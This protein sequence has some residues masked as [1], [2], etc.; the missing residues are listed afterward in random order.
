MEMQD[1][2]SGTFVKV[3]EIWVGKYG[4]A[5]MDPHDLQQ[6]IVVADRFQMTEV[7]AALEEAVLGQVKV[8]NCWD[9]L[10]WSSEMGMRQLEAAALRLAAENFEEMSLAA[11]FMD[12]DEAA[13]G[14]LLD[15]DG[16][17]A[18]NEEAVCEALTRWMRAEEGQLRGRG[19]LGKVR[20]PLM[21]EGFLTSKAQT[22]LPAEHAD[23]VE[24]FV[25]EALLAKRSA[26][27][28]QAPLAARLLG[29]RALAPRARRGV[30]WGTCAD[31]GERRLAGHTAGV[32]A[33]AEC[34]GR[35]CSASL[36]GAIWVWG[37]ATR[38]PERLLHGDADACANALAAWG[39]RLVSGHD[40]GSLRVWDVRTGVCEQALEGHASFVLALAACGPARLASG[41]A[42][43]T[44]RLWAAG[45]GA[46]APW[47][48]ERTLVGHAAGVKALAAWGGKVLSGS[49]DATIRVW[50]AGTGAHDATLAGHADEVYGLAVHG[51]R[52]LSASQ[53]GAIR[54]WA[55]GA[56][57]PLRAVEAYP[58]GA[59]QF[60]RCLAVS[61]GRLVSGSWA[62]FGDSHTEVRVWD[63]AT[64]RCERAL[65]QPVGDDVS[66]FV[67]AE[68]ELWAGVGEAVVVWGR[69]GGATGPRERAVVEA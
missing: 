39:G 2:D 14:A 69:R 20:F 63:L 36:D 50:D 21:D 42:D 24:G 10:K 28:A 13:L 7:V 18:T 9:I 54:E 19:L 29:P 57:A 41:S 23:W 46:G 4:M 22:L 6:L 30:D 61:G 34:E 38:A 45:A 56:W 25:E 12:L 1:V 58:R 55:A 52:L 67:V 3:L 15:D 26:R 47:A 5:G 59:G 11:G 35:V 60:P 17:I 43:R 66:G 68:G 40:D 48:C 8:G 37:A 32:V 33:V 31:G 27:A 64:L 65:R 62:A 51:D 16:L 49:A 44:V 53:D